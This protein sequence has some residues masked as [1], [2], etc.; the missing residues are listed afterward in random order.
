MT[1][2]IQQAYNDMDNIVNNI[3]SVYNGKPLAPRIKATED[4][5]REQINSY[6][7]YLFV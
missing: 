2:Q 5:Q 1:Q 4:K 6:Q 3:S 7:L